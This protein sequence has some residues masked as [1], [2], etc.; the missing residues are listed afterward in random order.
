MHYDAGTINQLLH[1]RCTHTG[2]DELDILAAS[3]N[4]EEISIEIY[5]GVTKWNTVRGEDTHFPSKD[6][7]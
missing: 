7:H 2:T 6:L 4:M 3:A 5:G 1:L